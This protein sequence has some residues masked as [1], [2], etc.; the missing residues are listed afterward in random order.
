MDIEKYLEL[1]IQCQ[2]AAYKALIKSIQDRL[3]GS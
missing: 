3:K 1:Y 2:T